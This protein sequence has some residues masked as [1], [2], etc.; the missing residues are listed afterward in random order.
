MLR[1]I[2]EEVVWTQTDRQICGGIG[3]KTPVRQTPVCPAQA[4]VQAGGSLGSEARVMV[5]STGVRESAMTRKG[6]GTKRSF[7]RSVRG[8]VRVVREDR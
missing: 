4:S 6:P 1:G 3:Q 5:G 8:K 7:T 2:D